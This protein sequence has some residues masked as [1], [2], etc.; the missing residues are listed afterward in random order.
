[1]VPVGASA[2]PLVLCEFSTCTTMYVTCPF[3]GLPFWSAFATNGATIVG[4]FFATVKVVA[5]D[6]EA[7]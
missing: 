3:T 6:V 7:L 5:A 2:D 1:M 4:V